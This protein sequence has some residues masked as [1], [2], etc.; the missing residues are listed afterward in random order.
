MSRRLNRDTLPLHKPE[1]CSNFW[2]LPDPACGCYLHSN[3]FAGF[4]GDISL[5]M[6]DA[7]VYDLRGHTYCCGSERGSF[8][9]SGLTNSIGRSVQ[10][11][12]LCT[13]SSCLCFG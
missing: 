7:M 2:Q 8:T 1:A 11:P 10:P 3:G 6:E 5:A 4:V 12:L 13:A 9:S